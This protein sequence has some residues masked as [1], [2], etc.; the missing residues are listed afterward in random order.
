MHSIRGSKTSVHVGC[1]G[2]DYGWLKIKA[3][4][5]IA[6]YDVLGVNSSMNASRISHFFDFR[7]ASMNIDT[8]C[9][10]SLV[11]LDMA[12]QSLLMG[13]TD[14]VSITAKFQPSV[15][16]LT[17]TLKGIV[18]GMNLI[19]SPDSMIVLSGV[20]MLSPSGVSYSFDSRA[21]GYGR[22]EGF[23]V[24]VLKRLSDALANGDTIRAI[25]R[26]TGSAQDGST[27]AGIMQPS[28]DTQADLIRE[29]YAK[30]G[31]DMN[32]TR[33]FE[34]HGTGTPVGDPIEV[35]SFGAIFRNHRTADEPLYV[36]VQ[37]N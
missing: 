7:G 30:A 3:S 15:L 16:L 35:N 29:T 10:S 17:T 11:A 23:G 27:S 22:G 32:I 26:A 5:D 34:A 2:T 14:M 36:Y 21:H 19:I 6:D 1:F 12:C 4:E 8:A 28:G 33:Y 20:N 24:V 31:L 37:H 13:E 18:A 25:I 9:S